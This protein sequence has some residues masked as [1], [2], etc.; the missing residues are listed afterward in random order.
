MVQGR[1]K[2]QYMRIKGQSTGISVLSEY[3]YKNSS[4]FLFSMCPAVLNY[5][6]ATSLSFFFLV[7]TVK[8]RKSQSIFD[9]SIAA[10]FC[11]IS[12]ARS[13]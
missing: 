8:Q 11:S 12:E 6:S 5:L 7:I 2:A 10:R 13:P 1:Q 4:V 9:R 3:Y